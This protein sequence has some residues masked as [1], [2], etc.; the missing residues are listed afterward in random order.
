V[1]ALPRERLEVAV[2]LAGPRTEHL[3]LD[4]AEVN[5]YDAKAVALELVERVTGQNATARYVG[6]SDRTKHLHPRGAA[7]VVVGDKIVGLFG[8]FHPDVC[9]AFNLG[10]PAQVV[11]LDLDAIEALGRT[12]PRFQGIPRLPAVTR[13]L[14][15]VVAEGVPAGDVARVLGKAGGELCES[16]VTL[17]EFRGGSVPTGR[18]SLTFRV[19]YRD[20]KARR[21]AADARTLTDQEVDGVEAKML[22]AARAELDAALRS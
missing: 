9:D 21:D 6:A 17:A 12:T 18:R 16:I 7:E 22:E 4:P 11:E 5:V 19:V 3:S 8:P 2:I 13:D 20:P 10:G 15:L 14:S 1:G